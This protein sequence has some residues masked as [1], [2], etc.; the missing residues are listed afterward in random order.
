M[1]E[2][3]IPLATYRIQFSLGFRFLDGRDLVPYLN[4]LGITDLYSSP[5]FKARR[6]SPHAYDVAD[7]HKINSELGTEDEFRELAEKLRAYG[8]GLVLDIVPNHMAA[9]PE[10]PWWMDVLE[11]GRN[12]LYTHHFAIDW[13][14]TCVKSTG[15][16]KVVLPILGDLYGAVLQSGQLNLKLDENGFFVKFHEHRLPIDPKTYGT[17]LTSCR[18]A[19]R[20]EAAELIAAIESLPAGKLERAEVEERHRRKQ[21]LKARLWSLYNGN[22]EFK[23][24][25]D[26]CVMTTN[27]TP[28]DGGT[29]DVLD[30][31][32]SQ[33]S[34]RVAYW[35]VAGE[36]LNYRRFFDITDLIGVRVEDPDVFDARH[37]EI[38][39]LVNGRGVTALRVDHIDGLWDPQGY[40][41]RLHEKAGGGGAPGCAGFYIIVEKILGA[42]EHLPRDWEACGTTGYDFLGYLNGLFIDPE[43][44]KKLDGIYRRFTGV[45]A[46]FT[47]IRYARKKQ[48]MEELFAGEVRA[49][50]FHLGRLAAQDRFAR[51]LPFPELVQALVEV[52]AWFPVYRTYIRGFEIAPQDRAYIEQALELA[53]KPTSNFNPAVLD[54]LRRV[55]LLEIPHYIEARDQ[56]L[57]FVRDWQQFTGP[58]MA[59]GYEDTACYFYNRL[60]SSNEVGSDHETADSPGGVERFHRKNRER[61][62]DWPHSMNATSSHDTKRSE[63][64]RARINVLSEIPDVWSRRLARW[65]AWND[66][67]KQSVD[68]LP[69]PSRNDEMLL[70]QTLI[71]AWPLCDDELPAF[72]DRIKN[73][74]QKA[75]REAK[76]HSS[77]L[78][79]DEPYE[80]AC[81]A[82]VDAI[83]DP[84]DDNLFRKD[85]VTFQKRVASSGAVNSLAQVLLK[86]A[87]PGL[88]DFYQGTELWDFSLVDPDNRRPVDFTGRTALLDE[89]RRREASDLPGLLRE[90]AANWKDGRIKLYLTYKALNFRKSQT[91]LFENGDYLPLEGPH[92]CAF[93]RRNDAAWALAVAPRLIA[94]LDTPRKRLP[95]SK[96]FGSD[97]LTLPPD[98][99]ANWRNVLTSEEFT[100]AEV[101]GAKTLRLADLFAN[102]P[103]ALLEPR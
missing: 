85:F 45:H 58:V 42:D 38:V 27:G 30:R 70:Y 98:A 34:Y 7:P 55:L 76:T 65:S 99:P 69:A 57:G 36:E 48:V 94:C 2:L 89:L 43:G 6:G 52:T 95:A 44:L 82:F 90:I 11:N 18:A 73:F 51:D 80:N 37:P 15:S 56:W 35:R 97:V 103:V 22:A 81:L 87:S 14:R 83:L 31:L 8:M 1:G 92:T 39:D 78:H 40:L 23:S 33:Q 49:V 86:I 62:A 64:V 26:E 63:D 32:L 16:N 12:S 68:E 102:F 93:A 84:A 71:G 21:D 77:W 75:V 19:Q 59:K 28:G 47:E 91:A 4:D 29:F 61:L 9:S 88:P 74:L 5:Q 41:H 25:L 13:E 10:N 67:K 53:R 60:I 50:G 3:R 100:A 54:F 17:I 101:K 20:S 72:R 46:D 79:P 66:P 96:V 24:A